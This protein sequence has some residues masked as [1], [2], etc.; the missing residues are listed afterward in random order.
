MWGQP[1]H[2]ALGTL[3]RHR[4]TDKI[5]HDP[6]MLHDPIHLS[7]RDHSALFK[8]MQSFL[9]RQ[10]GGPVLKLPYRCGSKRTACTLPMASLELPFIIAFNPKWGTVKIMVPFWVPIIIRGLI[11]GLI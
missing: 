6:E 10:H 4:L 9:H 5:L 11:R 2:T 7:P 8:V 1:L 3:S